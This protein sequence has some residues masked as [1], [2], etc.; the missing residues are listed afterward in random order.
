MGL[1]LDLGWKWLLVATLTSGCG[2]ETEEVRLRKQ[3]NVTG[4][5]LYAALKLAAS[6]NP[7]S[8]DA[9]RARQLLTEL[10]ENLRTQSP[11]DS[12]PTRVD[13]AALT[14]VA[15]VL[16]RLRAAGRG[17]VEQWRDSRVSVFGDEM[18]EQTA[19]SERLAAEHGVLLLGLTALRLHPRAPAP[20]PAE[21][22]LYEAY[23]FG[24]SPLANS[25]LEGMAR[26]AQAIV[27]AR[28]EY[29][30]LAAVS[31]QRLTQ[32]RL[33]TSGDELRNVAEL[34]VGLGRAAAHAPPAAALVAALILVDNLPWATRLL[35]FASSAQCLSE[36]SLPDARQR[37]VV[38]WERAVGVAEAV[39]FPPAELGFL[40]AY[41]AYQREDFPTVQREL[42]VARES[43]LLTPDERTQLD[44]L[45][46]HFDPQDRTTLDRFIDPLFVSRWVARLVHHRLESAGFY[47]ALGEIPALRVVSGVFQASSIPD[48][49]QARVAGNSGWEWLKARWQAWM[50]EP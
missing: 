2:A 9:K 16:W 21:A 22:V 27:Y 8:D 41:L 38:E 35:A 24:D 43:R 7:E 40:R 33:P 4:T 29:C 49:A 36:S 31:T 11:S 28:E 44:D 15:S 48:S 47:R 5:H 32:I 39:G 20:V 23:L 42:A 45:V 26:S 30:E 46:A 17:E 50:S 3:V 1:H 25:D 34:A 10:E 19:E 13:L 6:S 37:A 14:E 12:A 18:F